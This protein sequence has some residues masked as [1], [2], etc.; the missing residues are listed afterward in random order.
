MKIA[1]TIPGITEAIKAPGGAPTG[2]LFPAGGNIIGTL[3]TIAFLV[4]IFFALWVI[5]RSGI[6][7]SMSRG[8]KEKVQT[9]RARIQYAVV[10]LV[11]M[12][13]S[14]MIVNIIGHLAGVKLIGP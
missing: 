8:D 13:L 2:G 11:M 1:L 7:W 4:S 5:V 9:A 14:F 6:G 3:I 10:G 12:F